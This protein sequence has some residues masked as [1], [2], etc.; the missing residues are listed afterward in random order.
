MS[1]V[2]SYLS[3][4]E[5]YVSHRINNIDFE[6]KKR[7][8]PLINVVAGIGATAEGVAE[9]VM[10]DSEAASDS[11]LTAQRHLFVG[12]YPYILSKNNAINRSSAALNTIHSVFRSID[13]FNPKKPSRSISYKI[14]PIITTMQIAANASEA[15]MMKELY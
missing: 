11:F 15:W 6:S 13:N 10:G 5:N 3:R 12:I 14:S 7:Y 1:K 8:M 2:K 9:Y 4:A